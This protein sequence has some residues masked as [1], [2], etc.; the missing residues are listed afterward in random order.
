[1]II[2][3]SESLSDHTRIET[4]HKD[5][6]LIY[7]Q[8]CFLDQALKQKL[9]K[10][11]V[12]IVAKKGDEYHQITTDDFIFPIVADEL[13]I[14]SEVDG[15]KNTIFKYASMIFANMTL[16][17]YKTSQDAF[18]GIMRYA[19]RI[20]NDKVAGSNSFIFD[21]PQN[22][23]APGGAVP[24]VYG[25]CHTGSIVISASVTASS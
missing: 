11:N 24:L 1:M 2:H 15:S 20:K 23:T 9:S 21:Q 12:A 25:R 5:W 3:L 7:R 4:S 8:L 17:L 16:G 22:V 6:Q 13:H 14:V 18:T 19:T 10:D